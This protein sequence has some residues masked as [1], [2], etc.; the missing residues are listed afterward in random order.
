MDRHTIYTHIHTNTLIMQ[1]DKTQ[2]IYTVYLTLKWKLKKFTIPKLSKLFKL[3]S[4]KL[5]KKKING[6]DGLWMAKSSF[7][8]FCWI[9]LTLSFE[10]WVIEVYK[11]RVI[12]KW[13]IFYYCFL[14]FNSIILFLFN[15]VLY[16]QRK[17]FIYTILILFVPIKLCFY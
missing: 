8:M 11:N 2:N 7:S 13:L 12:I 14:D 16:L 1:T 10:F 4:G 3:K 6:V 17:N 15:L 9:S 5:F